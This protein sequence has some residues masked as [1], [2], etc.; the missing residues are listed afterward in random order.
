[1]S[2]SL[3]TSWSSQKWEGTYLSHYVLRS[4]VYVL[5]LCLTTDMDLTEKLETV[6]SMLKSSPREEIQ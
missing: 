4:S 2:E 1:M 6:K 3:E 5:A